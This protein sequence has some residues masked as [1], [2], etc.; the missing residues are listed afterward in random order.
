ME[1]NCILN[2]SARNNSEA[3]SELLKVLISGSWKLSPKQGIWATPMRLRKPLRWVSGKNTTAGSYSGK[4]WNIVF[5]TWHS[6]C[7]R[8]LES[9]ALGL[10]T[11]EPV[12]SQSWTGSDSSL[13]SYW[14][15]N[16]SGE[17]R[18]MCSS[19]WSNSEATMIQW[20]C[21]YQCFSKTNISIYA[22]VMYTARMKHFKLKHYKEICKE[23]AHFSEC[24]LWFM[25]IP[26][27]PCERNPLLEQ[28]KE[29][30]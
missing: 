27:Q 12:H 8:Q 30:H 24:I 3:E 19:Y 18:A 15:L 22:K 26:A 1:P 23:K 16:N 29:L 17:G 4:Q 9:S 21:A 10:Y 6:H 13:L 20:I 25:S 5:R 2:L 7:K 28:D 11:T 14:L